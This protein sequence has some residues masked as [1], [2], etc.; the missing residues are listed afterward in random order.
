MTE[1]HNDPGELSPAA[2]ALSQAAGAQG[3]PSEPW[4]QVTVTVVATPPTDKD[5][6]RRQNRWSQCDSGQC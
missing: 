2:K 3:V 1:T 6:R 5:S 4:Q